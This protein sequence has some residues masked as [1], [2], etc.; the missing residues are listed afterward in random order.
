MRETHGHNDS[1]F[2][3]RRSLRCDGGRRKRT[4]TWPDAFEGWRGKARP[5]DREESYM[6]TYKWQ[7]QGSRLEWDIEIPISTYTYCTGRHRTHTYDIYIVD[8]L[9]APF[10]ED[11][12]GQFVDLA[13]KRG[14][15]DRERFT[16]VVR[17]VQSLPYSLDREDTGHLI[18][19]KFPIET[20]V[21]GRGD[22]E[23]GTLLLGALLD[24]LD[25]DIAVLV[26][27]DAQHMLL[28][29]A[30]EGDHGSYLEYHGKRYYPIETTDTGWGVGEMPPQCRGERA[31]I[32]LPGDNPVLVHDW[33]ASPNPDDSIGVTARVANFG[34]V[35]AESIVTQIEFERR[36]GATVAKRQL[37]RRPASLAPTESATYECTLSLPFDRTLRGKLT[38]GVDG[39]VHDV[40]QSDWR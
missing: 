4:E 36:D 15:D 29:V 1:G 23:D 33:E 7:F 34:D 8:P 30:L 18:Y 13:E 38:I 32:H 25:R 16:S 40:S 35:T 2:G 26:F 10:I 12:A 19:P 24:S 28:G 9:Q 6:R 3:V 11:L 27:P 14:L 22:C 21:H 20:L 17:F 31:N 5:T 37:N 39:V